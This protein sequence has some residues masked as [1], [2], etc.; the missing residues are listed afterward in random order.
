MVDI[1]QDRLIVEINDENELKYFSAIVNFN[2]IFS[3]DV[4]TFLLRRK[5]LRENPLGVLKEFIL[6]QDGIVLAY[7]YFIPT[8]FNDAVYLLS[9]G[10]LVNPA[11]KGVFVSFYL[12]ILDLLKEDG[13]TIVYGFP[14]KNSYPIMIHR[15]G[16]GMLADENYRQIRIV[17][18][19]NILKKHITEYFSSMV[20]EEKFVGISLSPWL[21]WRISK[22]NTEYKINR[23]GNVDV[24]YKIYE[25]QIDLISI[26]SFSSYLEYAST[27]YVLYRK[28]SDFHSDVNLILNSRNLLDVISK[29][30]EIEYDNYERHL[31]YKIMDER[32]NIEFNFLAEMIYS[33]IY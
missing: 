10:S 16:A 13:N 5:W 6:V 26:P 11:Y 7:N 8:P 31:C 19:K 15:F 2:K 1:V 4:N 9:G 14:N 28:F 30:F 18:M 22:P 33:D 24:I 25:N 27:I 29:Y 17:G 32:V 12:D 20:I 21:S 3:E 23:I